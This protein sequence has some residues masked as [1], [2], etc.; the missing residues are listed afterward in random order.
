MSLK[1]VGRAIGSTPRSG[2]TIKPTAQAVGDN[3][4]ENEQAPKGRKKSHDAAL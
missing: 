3:A 1:K 4:V 2:D